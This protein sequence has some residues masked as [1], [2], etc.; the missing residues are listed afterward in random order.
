MPDWHLFAKPTLSMALF[1]QS[2]I[3][4]HIGSL[5]EYALKA[6][7]V[8]Y[9]AHFH[10]AYI[11]KNIWDAKEEEYQEGFV[12]DLFVSILG[13]TLKPQPN[14]NLVLEKKTETDATKSDGALLRDD[15]IIGV[16]ELKD[17]GTT[18]L[19][20]IEGQVFCRY[21]LTASIEQRIEML[22]QS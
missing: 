8:K 14:Y 10:N 5:D 18:E 7:W 1:Q 22:R 6:A 2:V 3:K 4:K 17:T 19:V 11:Q 16:I 21:F 9:Q 20:K 12:R 15:S 13:Y